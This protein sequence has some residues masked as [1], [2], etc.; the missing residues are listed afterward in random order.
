MR[1]F[2]FLGGTGGGSYQVWILEEE[3]DVRVEAIVL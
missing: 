3:S 1:I 2:G